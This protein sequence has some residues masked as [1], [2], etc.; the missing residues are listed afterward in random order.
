[1][2]I[3]SIFRGLSILSYFSIFIKGEII[4]GP[5]FF[6]M[7]GALYNSDT[8]TQVLVVLAFTGLIALGFLMFIPKS[9]WTL[10]TEII[11]FIFL[12]FP[13]LN[14]LRF[15][16]I[17]LL[18]YPLFTTPAISFVLLYLLS[19]LFSFRDYIQQPIN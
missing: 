13:I 12:L 1:M 3:Y 8:L 15:E 17:P 11:V 10:I 6:L 14:E 19:L 9:E 16:P 18:K 4:S 7:V 5:M 2:K